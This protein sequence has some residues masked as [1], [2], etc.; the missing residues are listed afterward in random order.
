VKY[1]PR[2]FLQEFRIHS[3]EGIVKE[4]ET[5]KICRTYTERK[6]VSFK[7]VDIFVY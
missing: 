1:P 3:V 6:F 2:F 7:L 5:K 4:N